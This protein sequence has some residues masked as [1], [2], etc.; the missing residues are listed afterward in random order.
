MNRNIKNWYY[1]AEREVD[2][3]NWKIL[4]FEYKYSRLVRYRNAQTWQPLVYIPLWAW[5]RDTQFFLGPL[6]VQAP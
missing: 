6:Y 2:K 4:I 3:S 1:G 5:L